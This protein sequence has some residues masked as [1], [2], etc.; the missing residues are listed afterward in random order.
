MVS[1]RPGQVI[2][3]EKEERRRRLNIDLWTWL[4]NI[5]GKKERGMR[6]R[7]RSRAA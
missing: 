5:L 6:E 1:E 3:E 7:E 4:Q 2:E